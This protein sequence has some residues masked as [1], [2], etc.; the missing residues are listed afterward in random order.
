MG[1]IATRFRGMSL[2]LTEPKVQSP[3][4]SR[5]VCRRT[6][7]SNSAQS[8]SAPDSGNLRHARF[9]R[10]IWS[11]VSSSSS[12]TI[13]RHAMHVPSL[14]SA[15][16]RQTAQRSATNQSSGSQRSCHFDQS[17]YTWFELV[18]AGLISRALA[19]SSVFPHISSFVRCL[20]PALPLP[21]AQAPGDI[22]CN[23]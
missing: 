3:E 2:T 22:Y 15:W 14:P 16:G 11:I 18:R 9:R 8:R 12:M 6:C 21:D 5:A 10:L 20:P 7:A 4:R 17:P 23:S 1:L 13:V 19:Q